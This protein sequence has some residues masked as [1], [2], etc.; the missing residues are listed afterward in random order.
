MKLLPAG[1]EY[2]KL[3]VDCDTKTVESRFLR[4]LFRYMFDNK[5]AIYRL[6]F[7]CNN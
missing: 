6:Y 7:K 2:V 3:N 1:D 4:L 5:I